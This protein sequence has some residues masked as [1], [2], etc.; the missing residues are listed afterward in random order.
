LDINTSKP[1][2][3]LH[4][5][6]TRGFPSGNRSGNKSLIAFCASAGVSE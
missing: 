5:I 2:I 6:V 4:E 3:L 1:L